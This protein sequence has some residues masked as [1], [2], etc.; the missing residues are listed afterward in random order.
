[1]TEVAGRLATTIVQRYRDRFGRGP[2]EAKAVI[3]DDF[4]L[5]ILGSAQTEVERSLVAGGELDSVEFLRRQVLQVH[6]FLR[7]CASL[8]TSS[9]SL[10]RPRMCQLTAATTTSPQSYSSRS[11]WR[12]ASQTS[13]NRRITWATETRPRRTPGS[14]A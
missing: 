13:A 14:T 5:V 2:T 12:D 1:M 6:D 9:R 8:L 4:A 11:S 3:Q 7:T 10:P